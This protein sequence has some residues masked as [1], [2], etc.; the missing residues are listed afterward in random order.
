MQR[1][2]ARLGRVGAR[3]Q[4]ALLGEERVR[5]DAQVRAGRIVIGEGSYGYPIVRTF[6]NEDSVRLIVGNYCSLASEALFLL[7]GEHPLDRVSTFPFRARLGIGRPV[8]EAFQVA[9]S[10]TVLGSDVWVAAR[11]VILAGTR[12]G[13][14]AVV[15][16]GAV[17]TRDVPAYAVVAG[18]PA[19]I[20]GF[21]HTEEVIERL[22]QIQWWEWPKG[23]IEGIVE[24]LSDSSPQELF[25]YAA[26]RSA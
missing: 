17:V 5:F 6:V 18:S 14:G 26:A 23:E 13:N 16:A 19:R 12:I 3:V 15:A 8:G 24:L 10:D 4:G 22:E 7:G 21:R 2:A 11:A 20:V 1:I 25:R 9:V